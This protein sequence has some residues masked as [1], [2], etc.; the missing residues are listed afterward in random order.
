[1][2]KGGNPKILNL[3]FY[4]QAFGPHLGIPLYLALIYSIKNRKLEILLF[5][6]GKIVTCLGNIFTMEQIS[7]IFAALFKT[8]GM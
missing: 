2:C 8:F 7:I 4:V 1:M 5:F 3:E 6:S